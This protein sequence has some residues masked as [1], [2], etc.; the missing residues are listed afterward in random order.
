MPVS[1]RRFNL[2]V[3]EGYFN[4]YVKY[5]C[6]PH[7]SAIFAYLLCFF[8]FL[9][10]IY[11]CAVAACQRVSLMCLQCMHT[12]FTFFFSIYLSLCPC[13]ILRC[14]RWISRKTGAHGFSGA[15][16]GWLCIK[17][18]RWK[19]C[20]SYGQWPQQGIWVF[21]SNFGTVGRGLDFLVSL[22]DNRCLFVFQT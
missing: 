14:C 15:H 3:D 13:S 11:C 10:F 16:Q 20:N 21:L 4:G 5:Q 1:R 6:K 18:R 8:F 7:V 12:F 22:A 9:L 17:I 2:F 19:G